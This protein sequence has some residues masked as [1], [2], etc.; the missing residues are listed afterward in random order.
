MG[1]NEGGRPQPASEGKAVDRVILLA[2]G[3]KAESW[4]GPFETLLWRLRE[5]GMEG[6]RGKLSLA[7]MEFAR[8]G[9]EES[10]DEARA[11]SLRRLAVLPLFIAV[12]SHVGRDIPRRIA[13]YRSRFPEI[14][15]ELLP[16][17]GEDPEFLDLLAGYISGYLHRRLGE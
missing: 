9:L 17:L 6:R 5:Q 2:H 13:A 1:E 16:A 15:I 8:P 4:K 11:D 3:S 12:G 10:F 14:E 7:Y